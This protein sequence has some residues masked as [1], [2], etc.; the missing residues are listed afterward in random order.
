MLQDI[1]FAA[2]LAFFLTWIIRALSRVVRVVVTRSTELGYKSSDAEAVLNRCHSLF[3]IEKL[4]FNGITIQRGMLVRVVT[5][6]KITIEGEFIGA[7]E[8]NMV[9]FLTPH[10][11]VAHELG[12]IEEMMAIQR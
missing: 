2:I 5:N 3:P 1:V 4:L 6:R 8:D 9:C 10:S 7:N 11:V 12:N